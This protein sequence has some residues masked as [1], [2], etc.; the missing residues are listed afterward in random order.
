MQ[1]QTADFTVPH[2]MKAKAQE[3]LLVS[4]GLII[5]I[6][7]TVVGLVSAHHFLAPIVVAG[8]LTMIF[9]PLA[10]HLERMGLSR[11]WSSLTS[12][13][14]AFLFFFGLFA[15][16]SMQMQR[17]ASEWPQIKE[18]VEP[19][20][21]EVQ[22]WVA[23]TTGIDAFTQQRMVMENLPGQE[24]GGVEE[25]DG[26]ETSGSS[27][28]IQKG[29]KKSSGK[30]LV[31]SV[32]KMMVAFF[33]FLGVAL[34]TG[35]YLFFM[36]LYRAKIRLS[37]LHFF[38]PHQKDEA[39]NVIQESVALSQS[40]LLGRFVLIFILAVFY[41][42]GLALSGVDQAII[43]SILAALLSL[44]PYI[45]NVVG[46]GLAIAMA[47]FSGGD[48]V[49]FIGVTATFSIAQ[50]VESYILEPYIVGHRVALNPLTT[51]IV[52]VLGGAVWGIVGMII[53]IPLVG[54]IKIVCDR[55]PVL[56]SVGY[57][58]GE[59]DIESSSG[60]NALE[61]WAGRIQKRF[62]KKRD[63]ES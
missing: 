34:L 8:L 55:I 32:S 14:T 62:S 10:H 23:R 19:R 27:A 16:L 56:H 4:V 18:R 20:I 58:L 31:K 6:Y 1:N 39:N 50:F 30:S 53:F 54:I 46:F 41:S 2:I 63:Q 42:I 38:P 7:F 22:D 52:V 29:K 37:I 57:M 51:V 48:P 35:V 15:V 36:L 5:G 11:G 24:E 45:G 3:F 40:Y 44:V 9:L 49:A 21:E 59:E 13:L 43:I 33:S 60:E 25:D 61:R 47:A 12:V 28:D 17:I 26:T